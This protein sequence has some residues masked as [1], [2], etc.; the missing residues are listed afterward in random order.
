MP[1][2]QAINVSRHYT[3]MH[4]YGQFVLNRFLNLG[5][6]VYGGAVRNYI[7][8][9]VTKEEVIEQ[10]GDE[11]HFMNLH[12]PDVHRESFYRR[13]GSFADIDCIGTPD[14]LA[15]LYGSEIGDLDVVV[16][17]K[18]IT[19]YTF[20]I[21]IEDV[22]R[23]TARVRSNIPGSGFDVKIDMIICPGEQ[24][25]SL[26][27][28]LNSNLDFECN[29]FCMMIHD[30]VKKIS[31]LGGGFFEHEELIKAEMSKD[32][33]R[34]IKPFDL[35]IYYRIVKM[36][37]YGWFVNLGEILTSV[38]E[39]SLIQLFA[40]SNELPHCSIC[41]E[42]RYSIGGMH[43]GIRI[44]GFDFH[45]SCYIEKSIICYEAFTGKK[46]TDSKEP[47]L[48]DAGSESDESDSESNVSDSES[49]SV[50]SDINVSNILQNDYDSDDS[51][52]S[53]ESIRELDRFIRFTRSQEQNLD[54]VVSNPVEE[55]L[56]VVGDV[57]FFHGIVVDINPQQLEQMRQLRPVQP[58]VMTVEESIA[59]IQ[60]FTLCS[61][62]V[63][64]L[65][66]LYRL[67]NFIASG[68]Y[69]AVRP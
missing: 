40:R 37:S 54:N 56:V 24:L 53:N 2:F 43:I 5:F 38:D 30:G 6:V 19:G 33:A 35:D 62:D 45:L 14:L 18:R 46:F 23:Y 57:A 15:K 60:Y 34:L 12:N 63:D 41:R 22:K 64:F 58:D 25:E 7:W 20:N 10:M 51:D 61:R 9:D 47:D 65:I 49:T 69:S 36:I 21:N 27:R 17:E 1:A 68:F 32:I 59:S 39:Y 8:R 67:R 66:A 13:T 44:N 28:L 3:E 26:Y 52:V 16:T 11:N 48:N 31:K 42:S 29:G 55:D 4:K 50:L